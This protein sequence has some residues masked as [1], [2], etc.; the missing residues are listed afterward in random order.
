MLRGE[1]YEVGRREFAT[2]SAQGG[3]ADPRGRL[4]PPIQRV[5]PVALGVRKAREP[6]YPGN[7]TAGQAVEADAAPREMPVMT[8]FEANRA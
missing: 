2:R 4:A 5:E 6:C 3:P 1:R 7:L 8:L